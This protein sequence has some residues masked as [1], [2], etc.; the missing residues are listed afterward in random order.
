MTL[1]RTFQLFRVLPSKTL[2]NFANEQLEDC[3]L[4]AAGVATGQL[5]KTSRS[6]VI[7]PIKWALN[8]SVWSCVDVG[9]EERYK[10][11]SKHAIN[12]TKGLKG[13]HRSAD[14]ILDL[15]YW[16]LHWLIN[17]VYLRHL[18]RYICRC[19]SRPV[20]KL[21]RR[22]HSSVLYFTLWVTECSL[23]VAES[24]LWVLKQLCCTMVNE[25]RKP[26]TIIEHNKR[27]FYGVRHI[28]N[29]SM[30]GHAHHSSTTYSAL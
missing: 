11:D 23:W 24:T 12:Q 22:A 8:L 1:R 28:I 30:L 18:S 3:I 14:S 13:W 4:P 5:S 17:A 26:T 7:L 15:Q 9:C 10:F 20:L 25:G 29:K 27:E 19:T 6:F 16:L 2:L 21:C